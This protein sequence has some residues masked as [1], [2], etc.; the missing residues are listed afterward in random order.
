MKHMHFFCRAHQVHLVSQ[1][2]TERP[3]QL[4][5]LDQQ[6]TRDL[7]VHQERWALLDQRGSRDRRVQ[8]GHRVILDH[9]EN[10]DSQ[11]ATIH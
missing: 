7:V 6:E 8:L 4:G 11:S 2:F 3:E 10:L 1:G 5:Q 9:L